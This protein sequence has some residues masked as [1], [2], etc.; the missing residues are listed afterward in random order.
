MTFR[1]ATA[2]FALVAICLR[3]GFGVGAAMALDGHARPVDDRLSDLVVAICSPDGLRTTADGTPVGDRAPADHAVPHC[4]L[5]LVPAI[6]LIAPVETSV[7][8]PAV[9]AT[10]V[11]WVARGGPP[12]LEAGPLHRFRARAPPAPATV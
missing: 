10:V 5:C 11:G 4:P 8:P 7:A 2:L 6:A 12:I 3:I 9:L 1:Q